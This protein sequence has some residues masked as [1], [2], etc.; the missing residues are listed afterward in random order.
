MLP[1]RRPPIA[2]AVTLALAVCGPALSPAGSVARDGGGGREVRDR[3]SCGRGTTSELR[4]RPRDGAIRARFEIDH[5]RPGAAWRIALVQDRRVVW[6]GRAR[7]S[8]R[9]DAVEIERR[10]RDLPGADRVVARAWGP[11][12][13]TCSVSATLAG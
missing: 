11:G 1:Y 5:T 2:T 10:I 7:V 12:G 6:R 8:G 3:A 4:L 13:L 9:A